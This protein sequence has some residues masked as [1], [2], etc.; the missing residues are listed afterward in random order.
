MSSI[1]RAERF[2]FEILNSKRF[3]IFSYSVKGD[4]KVIIASNA[5][6]LAKATGIYELEYRKGHPPHPSNDAHKRAGIGTA[7]RPLMFEDF[8]FRF[9]HQF[10]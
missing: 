6:E 10:S 4:N 3:S 2:I 8:N 9:F 1:A 7:P 5:A